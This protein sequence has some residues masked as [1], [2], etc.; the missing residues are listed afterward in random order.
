MS[1][2][3]HPGNLSTQGASARWHEVERNR[4]AQANVAIPPA[5][6][7]GNGGVIVNAGSAYLDWRHDAAQIMNLQQEVLFKVPRYPNMRAYREARR[8]ASLDP[9][10][11]YTGAQL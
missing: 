10:E 4:W 5:I 8:S 6:S 1:A 11:T 9:A 2:Y 3:R 7:K